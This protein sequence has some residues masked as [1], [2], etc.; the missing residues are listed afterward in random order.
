MGLDPHPDLP[1]DGS[2]P[3]PERSVPVGAAAAVGPS[4]LHH[5]EHHY[6]QLL[7]LHYM[8]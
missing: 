3:G 6:L 2:R 4:D 1:E 8:R 5:I 7:L